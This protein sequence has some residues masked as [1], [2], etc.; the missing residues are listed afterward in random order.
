M[1][2][3]LSA[4]LLL[5]LLSLGAP[6]EAGHRRPAPVYFAN[7]EDRPSN[8]S[9]CFIVKMR[10]HVPPADMEDLLPPA[11]DTDVGMWDAAFKG[12]YHCADACNETQLALWANDSRVEYIEE[13]RKVTAATTQTVSSL[14]WSL[15]RID[16]RSL[17][18]DGSFTYTNTGAGVYI[19]VV[20]TGVL[21]TH[22]ELTGR[23]L[24]GRSFVSGTA[25]D[26]TTDCN[27][28]GTHVS[29]TA[30]GITVG[31][32]KRAWIVPVRVLDCSG[33]GSSIA[34][35][36]AL[37]W[38]ASTQPQ[39]G[40]INLSLGSPASSA[41]DAAVQAV[42]A[43]G[44]VAVTAAGNS[45]DDACQ[46]SPARVSTAIT[47]GW[48][49]S[50]DARDSQSSYGTCVDLF[51]PG[52]LIYSA[53]YTSPT[54]YAQ[55]SGT[56]M[57]TALVSGVVAAYLQS[58]T[59]TS[60]AAMQAFVKQVATSGVLTSVG[61]GSPNL[62]VYSLGNLTANSSGAAGTPYSS[63]GDSSSG[64]SSGDNGS[65]TA[66]Y[67]ILVAPAVLVLCI[68]LSAVIFMA[69]RRRQLRAAEYPA[70]A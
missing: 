13:D 39:P 65:N 34:V 7:P 40:V 2:A 60:P 35:I 9:R 53:F 50:Q 62:L 38:I 28:H 49:T 66:L 52:S 14:L 1:A 15:D 68:A 46:Y 41:V 31:V 58:N 55:E 8:G 43:L 16:Q 61:T 51:A 48:T 10:D 37:N 17:P 56:S 26:N 5:L 47:V 25:S 11:N 70:A 18:L 27:G 19:Y 54:S 69:H 64:A 33:E 67:W 12:F 63:S 3:L 45:G 24:A 42:I 23:V 57:S 6:A 44:F 32:A 29:G 30:A 4:L 20:D 36:N 21:S 22:V 59:S